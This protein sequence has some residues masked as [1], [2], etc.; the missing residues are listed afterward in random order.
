MRS[1]RE[2]VLDGLVAVVHEQGGA[3]AEGAARL[4]VETHAIVA[5]PLFTRLDRGGRGV[6]RR[7]DRET[8]DVDNGRVALLRPRS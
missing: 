2:E 7:R 8:S 5:P 6:R 1:A 4:V 3:G